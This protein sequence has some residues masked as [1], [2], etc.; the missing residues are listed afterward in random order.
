MET[1]DEKVD[2][3]TKTADDIW[4]ILNDEATIR[5]EATACD[6]AQE[7]EPQIFEVAAPRIVAIAQAFPLLGKVLQ[8][9]S[10]QVCEIDPTAAVPEWWA[11][12]VGA[13]RPQ[14]VISFRAKTS[15]GKWAPST[16]PV[17]IPW[18]KD[19][20]GTPT[21]SP[22]WKGNHYGH[23]I[24]SDNSKLIVNCKS[25]SEAERVLGQLSSLI[26][27]GKLQG[28]MERYG[29]TKGPE[30]KQQQVYP[31]YMFY[32]STGQK[33]TSPDWRREFR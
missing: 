31:R 33:N 18:A 30:I 4:A 12:R 7:D 19:I 32:F 16:Y 3:V 27:P 2:E 11:T 8:F 26:E 10:Q 22:Y 24:L 17:S 21:L 15:N 20:A 6:A 23:L 1:L 28:A 5:I 25:Q 9:H 29:T 14:A 13:D